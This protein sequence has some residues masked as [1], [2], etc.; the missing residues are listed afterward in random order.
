MA[1]D[2]KLWVIALVIF[3][4]MLG[5]VAQI[6]LKKGSDTFV[7]TVKDILTNY[8]LI[9]GLFLYGLA[10]VLYL[11]ALRF[12]RV[13][14]LYPIISL[15]YIFVLFLSWKFFGESISFLQYIGAFMIVCGVWLII[16]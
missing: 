16:K 11:F 15:S 13:T 9:T 2:V 5:G 4:S 3:C 14:I 6:L 8:S 12:E 7:L 1:V 10:F